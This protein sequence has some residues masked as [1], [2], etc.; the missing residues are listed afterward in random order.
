MHTYELLCILPGTFAEDELPPHIAS[1]TT[2]IEEQGGTGVA[3]TDMGKN[4]LAYPMKHI[5]YG[6][7]YR[8][9]FQA[10]PAQ[11]P[12]IQKKLGLMTDLLRVMI[13]KYNEEKQNQYVSRM[14]EMQA[15][16][17]KTPAFHTDDEAEVAVKEEEKKTEK[18]AEQ[19]VEAPTTIADI[20]KE[21]DKILGDESIGD[22]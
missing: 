12:A 19:A 5:R 10:D 8:A 4:R 18:P 16:G 11:V 17:E 7:F 22:V 15:Q 21:L 9:L 2:A 1:I 13:Q 6:Y 14:A 20:D 3:V